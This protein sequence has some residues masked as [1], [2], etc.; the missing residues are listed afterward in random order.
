M[1]IIFL[2]YATS[3][4]KVNMANSACSGF[5]LMQICGLYRLQYIQRLSQL[6]LMSLLLIHYLGVRTQ[7]I[8][9][10]IYF[11]IGV[12]WPVQVVGRP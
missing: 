2:A 8:T 9:V 6:L 3:C 4:Y 10:G 12:L 5:P 11:L 1:V 7:N